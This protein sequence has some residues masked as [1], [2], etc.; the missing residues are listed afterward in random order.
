MIVL[1]H[2]DTVRT[3]MKRM[4]SLK[5]VIVEFLTDEMKLDGSV[6]SNIPFCL[7]AQYKES[8][9][10]PDY[11]IGEGQITEYNWKMELL[12][13]AVSVVP[14]EIAPMILKLHEKGVWEWLKRNQHL[15]VG[16][17]SLAFIV[18]LTG[19][20]SLAVVSMASTAGFTSIANATGAMVVG[21]ISSVSSLFRELYDKYKEG[22]Q[23]W[24][25]GHPKRQP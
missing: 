14:P 7:V 8:F 25:A 17:T 2:A 22:M 9:F 13:A 6:V 21:V 16:A 11:P 12:S 3:P 18:A 4:E 1:T 10:P 5:K 23:K 15:I 19:P 24:E 20:Q